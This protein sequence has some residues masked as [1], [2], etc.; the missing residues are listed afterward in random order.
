[1]TSLKPPFRAED[2]EGLYN[3]VIRGNYS[4]ILPVFSHELSTV[5]KSMLQVNPHQ[6]PTSDQ[7]LQFSVMVKKS[8]DLNIYNEE[9]ED[10]RV[11][12]LLKTIR[13]PKGNLHYLTDRLPKANYRRE[14][15]HLEG[16]SFNKSPTS[17]DRPTHESNLPMLKQI[18]VNTRASN[19][20]KLTHNY[21]G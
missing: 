20:R 12:E 21:R 10:S 7:L 14:L 4:K 15:E 9:S 1:M 5:I 8:R 6:R 16:G 11:S 17:P 13:M 3:K 18:N 2:M 19:P